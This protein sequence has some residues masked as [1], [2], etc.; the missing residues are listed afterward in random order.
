VSPRYLLDTNVLSEPLRPSPREVLMRRLRRHQGE[1]ATGSPVWH[2]LLF[3]CNRLAPSKKRTAIERYLNEVV[4]PLVPVLPYDAA[5]ARWH[6]AERARL[7]RIGK[8][9]SF[10]DGQ[11]AAI[12][13]ANELALVTANT[14]DYAGFSGIRIEDWGA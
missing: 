12:A 9:P 4:W 3:G 10:V 2:E 14:E 7:E 5:A 1:V 13:A 8:T 6:A 11:I